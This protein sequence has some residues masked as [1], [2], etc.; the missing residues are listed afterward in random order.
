M[1]HAFVAKVKLHGWEPRSAD[2]RRFLVSEVVAETRDLLAHRLRSAGCDLHFAEEAAGVSILGDP[3]RLAQV[4]LNLVGNA[5][6][7]YEDL[8]SSEGQI[9][10]TTRRTAE[11]IAITVRDWAGGM[12]AEVAARAFEEL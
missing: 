8:G 2:V 11:L 3:T 10:V 4:L 5:I 12:P 9:V 6:D 1:E 7:A